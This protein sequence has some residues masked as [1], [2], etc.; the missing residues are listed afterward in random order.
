MLPCT[1][2]TKF[3]HPSASYR[4]RAKLSGPAVQRFP[5]FLELFLE[6]PAQK[7]IRFMN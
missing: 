6:L 3:S 4:T 7:L 2:L 5:Q 1:T